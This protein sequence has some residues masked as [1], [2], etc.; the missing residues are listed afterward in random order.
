[1][2][3]EILSEVDFEVPAGARAVVVGP[4][5]CGK[6]TLLTT[7][8][9]RDSVEGRDKTRAGNRTR[10]AKCCSHLLYLMCGLSPLHLGK[11]QE[12]RHPKL[13]TSS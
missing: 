12:A 6:T 3:E 11:C 13:Q 2:F 5:G 1:M 8:A 9:T 10:E 7:I 4:N